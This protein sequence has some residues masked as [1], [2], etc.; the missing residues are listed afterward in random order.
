MAIA[1]A[2]ASGHDAKA[3][4]YVDELIAS[5][6]SHIGGA[7]HAVKSLCYV[8]SQ[9]ADMFRTDFEYECLTRAVSL[10][11]NDAWTLVQLADHLK[12][13][14][15]FGEAID[16][17]NRAEG[18]GH[19][20]VVRSSL[21]DVRAQMREFEKAIEIYDSIPGGEF[22]E[23]IRCARADALRR[24]GRLDDASREYD[25]MFADG[26]GSHRVVAGKAEIA[27]RKGSLPESLDLYKSL[28]ANGN[29]DNAAR[30]A[31]LMGISNVLVRMGN[32]ASAYEYLDAA[33]QMRPFSTHARAYRAAITGL[34]GKADEAIRELPSVGQ[35]KAFN[36]WVGGY[37]RGLLLLMLDRHAAARGALVEKV[38]EK[39]LDNDASGLLRLAAAVFFLQKRGSIDEADALL[40]DVPAI[41]DA[42]AD[43]VR[44]AL[45]FHVAVALQHREDIARLEKGLLTE[46][47]VDL[48][49]LTVAIKQRQWQ[50]ACRL[51]VRVLLRLAA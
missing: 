16:L 21:A 20:S 47:D 46:Q 1:E 48:R 15:R 22:D 28:L 4:Q 31:Y 12:R 5:Q 34:L 35:T 24:W 33:V 14:G 51:E 18:L 40:C 13:V 2:V 42:F 38:D 43:A 17:L 23:A 11:P 30:Y 3:R 36:E 37:V 45:Q 26:L 41:G 49:A 27:K 6:T 50:A 19:T 10:Q 44:S 9:C 7:K 32:L 39:V 8:A 29:L 25:R